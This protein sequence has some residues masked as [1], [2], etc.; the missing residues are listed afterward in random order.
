MHRYLAAAQTVNAPENTADSLPKQPELF[1]G[2][3]IQ[4]AIHAGLQVAAVPFTNGR[5]LDIGTPENLVKAIHN[6]AAQA[7]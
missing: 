1:V 2:D 7:T 3:V 5:Y 6:G 4:A